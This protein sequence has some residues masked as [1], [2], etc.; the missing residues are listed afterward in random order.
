MIANRL[1]VE[2]HECV[3]IDDML[4]N[5]EGASRAGMQAV[6]FGSPSQA[7]TDLQLVLADHA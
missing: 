7:Q 5:V 1:G 4:Q 3:M 2:P 6:L